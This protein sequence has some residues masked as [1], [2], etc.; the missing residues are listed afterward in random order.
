MSDRS[1]RINVYDSG[2][3][4]HAN[5]SFYLDDEHQY[6]IGANIRLEVPQL[7]IPRVLPFEPDDGIYR[8]ESA[9]HLSAIVEGTVISATVPITDLQYDELREVARSLENDTFNYS[10]FTEACI[11]LVEDFYDATGHPGEFGDLFAAEDRSGPLVWSRV[12][13]TYDSLISTWPDDRPLYSPPEPIMPDPPT[14]PAPTIFAGMPDPP[15]F[16]ID[17]DGAKGNT[18][19]LDRIANQIGSADSGAVE[20]ITGLP[21]SS[22]DWGSSPDENPVLEGL[23]PDEKPADATPQGVAEVT[24]IPAGE[25]TSPGLTPEPVAEGEAV[26]GP[27]LSGPSTPVLSFPTSPIDDYDI[28][29]SSETR[30][31]GTDVG[32]PKDSGSN[33]VEQTSL[34]NSSPA[35]DLGLSFDLAADDFDFQDIEPSNGLSFGENFEEP[36]QRDALSTPREDPGLSFESPSIDDD[37]DHASYDHGYDEFGLFI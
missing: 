2:K 35:Y 4:G 31:F 33:D 27:L 6:T 37:T 13:V 15:D 34:A 14:L 36:D 19:A 21:T 23:D 25:L 17:E 28:G 1:L 26:V 9:Y 30:S 8:D 32:E 18:Q 24:G 22:D 10:V 3:F 7:A 20:A 12:P 5:V 11:E 29:Q 16:L